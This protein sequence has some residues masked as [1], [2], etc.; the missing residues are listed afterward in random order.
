MAGNIQEVI[1]LQQAKLVDVIRG[2]L[3]ESQHSGSAVLVNSKGKTIQ[4][5]GQEDL[6]TY[7]RSAAKP[8]QVLPLVESGAAAEFNF[9]QEELAVMTASHSGE[10]LHIRL[11]KSILKKTGL[12]EDYLK[13]GTHLPYS[14]EA[15]KKLL[16]SGGEASPILNN[17]SGKHAGMLALCQHKGWDLENYFK[18]SHPLQQQLL[19]CVSRVSGY[20][21]ERIVTGE[22]GCGVVV[23]GL[24]LRNMALAFARLSDP[25]EL[26]G[27][28]R[29]PA[30]VIRQAM[31][32]NPLAVG[33]EGRFNSDL[34]AGA[35]GKILAKSG[36]E[37][38]FCLGFGDRGLAIKI[39]DGSSRAVPP[40]VMKFLEHNSVLTDGSQEVL[41]KY[42]K[43][44]V[45]NHRGNQVG[46]LRPTFSLNK[47]KIY[48][49][50]G[51][52]L[53]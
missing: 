23:Y 29:A 22:D 37:G 31:L 5:L 45:T 7:W 10:E 51:E 35:E 13:C 46:F 43:P 53:L 9:S 48:K 26:P 4:V 38:V 49:M 27:E 36:A 50:K 33:G 24:P 42:R 44:K 34:I 11:V 30:E 32:A 15:R 1:N 39:R 19:S 12:T 3:I 21:R 25:A 18:L 40:V 28:L 17:C 52:D 8:I 14:K 47:K 2:E 16:A 41:E 20:P 6:K